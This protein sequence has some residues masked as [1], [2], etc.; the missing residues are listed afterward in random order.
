QDT[1]LL[2]A[3]RAARPSSNRPPAKAA[4]RGIDPRGGAGGL[5]A[6]RSGMAG[7]PLDG[8]PDEAPWFGG[9]R[10]GLRRAVIRAG[11]KVFVDRGGWLALALS[12]GASHARAVEGWTALHRD[13]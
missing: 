12:R 8:S 3:R 7:G 4:S 9:S 5:A 13:G 2:P 11:Q 6:A 10:R 1:G